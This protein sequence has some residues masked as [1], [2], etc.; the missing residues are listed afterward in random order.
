MRVA[1]VAPVYVPV[2]PSNAKAVPVKYVPDAV[3]VKNVPVQMAGAVIVT[4]V[5]IA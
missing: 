4:I 3:I 2:V 5:I 1:T